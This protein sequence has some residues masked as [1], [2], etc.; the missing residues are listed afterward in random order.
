VSGV[1]VIRATCL[2]NAPHG[3]L[4]R[5]GGVSNGEL[6]GLNV[7][8]GS[9][10]DRSAIDE[11]RR[12]AVDALHS[13]AELATV[14]QV[15]SADV[16]YVE[17][18]WPQPER[19]QADAMVTDRPGLLLGILTADCAPV[20]FADPEAGVVAAAHAGWRGAL[21]GVTDST[22]AAMERLGATRGGI[23]A[24]VG[25]CIG[26]QSYEVD[27]VF[28]DRF[29]EA[30]PYNERFFERE[31]FGKPHFA[32]EAYVVSRLI[33]AGIEEV[34]ALHLDTYAEPDRFYSYRRATHR[35]EADYGRQLSAI[36]LA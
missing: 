13:D 28:R 30:D 12:R 3:F 1:E 9:S 4:G 7:G 5:R 14:H 27:E 19:P 20:L 17:Q 36:A 22:I 10:D 29:I 33:A 34:E 15:H 6:A 25:P 23:R 35:G 8:Y 11:N 32:L 31:T 2:G 21:A 26:Q 16:A 18:P 24:A